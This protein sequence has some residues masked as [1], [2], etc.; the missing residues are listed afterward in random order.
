MTQGPGYV[1]DPAGIAR[2]ALQAAVTDNG[3]TILS[4]A[5]MLDDFCRARLA[6]L[7]G[8][9]A[10]ISSAA[11]SDVPGLLRQQVDALGLD[12]A[13]VSVAATL[14]GAHSLNETA[15]VWVV[16]EFARVLGYPVPA[17]T[18]PMTV[19]APPQ[20]ATQPLP[21]TGS[22]APAAAPT[23][24]LATPS[25]RP[26]PGGIWANRNALGAAVAIMLVAAYLGIAAGV[27]MSP[28]AKAA[29]T[30]PSSPSGGSSSNGTDPPSNNSA[31]DP[32]SSD[33]DPGPDPQAAPPVTVIRRAGVPGLAAGTLPP[34]LFRT[35]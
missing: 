9:A 18:Q 3:P 22:T 30:S 16:T 4:D 35:V 17:R 27:H 33:P 11:R 24:L 2:G 14:S 12:A 6:G 13:I 5:A 26:G 29:S 19:T 28:F 20:T 34:S 10:L 15:C 21:A 1:I 8:E 32:R 25:A 23:V 7:P 31:P